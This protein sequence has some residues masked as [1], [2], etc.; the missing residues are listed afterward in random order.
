MP[1]P[2]TTAQTLV[3]SAL[4]KAGIVGIGET[5]GPEDINDTFNDLNDMLAQW[6]HE[7]A[8]IWHEVDMSVVST[9]IDVYSIGPG[10]NINVTVRPD[11]IMGAFIRQLNVS[12]T[13]PVDY[14]IKVVEAREDYNRLTLKK[15]IFTIPELI[16][17]DSEFPLGFIKPWPLMQA[18]IYELH[19]SLKDL[20]T[21]FAS[22]TT[23]V[24]LPLEY[25]PAMKWGLTQRVRVSYRLPADPTIDRQVKIAMTSLR[26]A[27]AQVPTLQM[28][29]TL[30]M[31]VGY[32]IYSDTVS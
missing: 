22:L 16:F 4:K 9:G 12:A 6:Q 28:P 7:R 17:Y 31:G 25:I 8:L 27:N 2:A 23:Q 11:R 24:Y 18:T 32:N 21:Q 14:P 15:G 5:P 10:G 13:T 20:L 30:G 19:V 26:R 3:T 29:A 1:A